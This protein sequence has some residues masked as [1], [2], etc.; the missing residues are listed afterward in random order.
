MSSLNVGTSPCYKKMWRRWISISPWPPRIPFHHHPINLWFLRF[1]FNY[2][3]TTT[4]LLSSSIRYLLHGRW[5]WYLK[6][7]PGHVDVI[8]GDQ[9]RANNIGLKT[10]N[11]CKNWKIMMI[12]LVCTM[13]GYRGILIFF[14][15]GP[16]SH[17]LYSTVRFKIDRDM[18]I[19][20]G[21]C[22]RLISVP[23]RSIALKELSHEIGSG[24]A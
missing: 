13:H 12:K 11:Q 4:T 8:P 6:Y 10:K 2:L 3:I 17:N 22:A 19:S 5:I 16:L 14:A 7:V 23:P 24:H 21:M 9:K 20:R 18:R 1:V 15:K